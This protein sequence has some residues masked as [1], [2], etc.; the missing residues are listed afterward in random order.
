MTQSRNQREGRYMG[1]VGGVYFR[2]GP[3]AVNRTR[4]QPITP[5]SLHGTAV[6]TIEIRLRTP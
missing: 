4:R 2:C 5:V 1:R 3:P 6:S